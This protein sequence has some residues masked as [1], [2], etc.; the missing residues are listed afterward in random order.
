MVYLVW[1]TIAEQLQHLTGVPA[2]WGS[3]LVVG[4]TPFKKYHIFLHMHSFPTKSAAG[5]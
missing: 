4:I 5:N 3:G 2:Q 1:G